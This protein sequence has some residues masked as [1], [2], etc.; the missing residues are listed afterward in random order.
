LQTEAHPLPAVKNRILSLF[1]SAS[2][3]VI[4]LSMIAWVFQPRPKIHP[5]V[6]EKQA[7][8]TSSPK[9][10]SKSDAAPL[11]APKLK[12]NKAQEKEKEPRGRFIKRNATEQLA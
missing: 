11:P 10:E 4:A 9:P 1:L 7:V 12:E 5:A 8:A 6:Q 2:V 3:L